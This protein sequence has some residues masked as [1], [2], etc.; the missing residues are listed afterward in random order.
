MFP[1]GT[2]TIPS[3]PLGSAIQPI[4]PPITY[5]RSHQ[6]TRKIVDH[7]GP[8]RDTSLNAATRSKRLDESRFEKN[9]GNVLEALTDEWTTL[10]NEIS[11]MQSEVLSNQ[12]QLATELRQWYAAQSIQNWFRAAL[13]RWKLKELKKLRLLRNWMFF[14]IYFSAR[15]RAAKV[16]KRIYHR[17]YI[18]SKFRYAIMAHRAAAKVQSVIIRKRKNRKLF[19]CIQLL[20][21]LKRAKDHIILFGMARATKRI[22]MQKWPFVYD[23]PSPIRR[24]LGNMIRQRRLR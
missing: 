13:S 18:Y 7:G 17:Y 11:E 22:V 4:P 1:V 21:S 23:T 19:E 3:A 16:V 24:L 5:R 10:F 15:R 20:V 8:R 6:F 12:I 9:F 14:R 2:A